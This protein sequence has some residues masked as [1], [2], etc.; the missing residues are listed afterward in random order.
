M[1]KNPKPSS[2]GFSLVEMVLVVSILSLFSSYFISNF[3]SSARNATARHQISSVM[4]SNIRKAQSMALSGT[5]I[6]GST[7]CGFGIHYLS[8][9]SYLI[10]AKDPNPQG[11]CV[12]NVNYNASSDLT[13]ETQTVANPNFMIQWSPGMG[14]R[15]DIFFEPPDPKTYIDNQ[16][17]SQNNNPAVISVVLN[18]NSCPG[19]NCTTVTVYKS[20]KIDVAN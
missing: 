8:Q 3:R 11:K 20:G 17:I 14:N 5:Q 19:A 10:Y 18:G 15:D 16:D 13:I 6:G 4:I 2:L 12:G 1:N 9:T 7:V